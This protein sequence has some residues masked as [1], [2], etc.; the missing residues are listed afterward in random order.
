MFST[1]A[2]DMPLFVTLLELPDPKAYLDP[3]RSTR[4]Q[5]CTQETHKLINLGKDLDIV[6]WLKV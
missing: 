2:V 3:M 1:A 4:N 6:R 5:S